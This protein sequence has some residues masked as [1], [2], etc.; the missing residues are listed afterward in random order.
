[1]GG[2][3]VKA[4]KE[5][6]PKPAFAGKPQWRLEKA[7]ERGRGGIN[8]HVLLGIVVS[9]DVD[10]TPHEK[11]GSQTASTGGAHEWNGQGDAHDASIH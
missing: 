7:A 4:F 10:V 11:E 2:W 6:R 3:E 8:K 9:N 5:D 1:M